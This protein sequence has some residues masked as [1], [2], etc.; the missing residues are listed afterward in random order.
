MAKNKK[1][2]WILWTILLYVALAILGFLIV[3]FIKN[4]VQTTKQSMPLNAAPSV[5]KS[6]QIT[7]PPGWLPYK[8]EEN[9]LSFSYPPETTIKHSSLGFGITSL[10]INSNDNKGTPEFQVL[11]APKYITQAAG[12]DF[13]KYYAMP[14]ETTISISSPLAKEK[15]PEQFTKMRNRTIQNYRALDYRSLPSDAKQ[16]DVAEIGVFIEAGDTII[17]ISTG[18]NNKEELEQL[19]GT[20]KHPI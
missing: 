18:E 8:N 16:G 1:H 5:S 19:V 12:Q 11:I 17:L 14:E 3:Y 9:H 13:N 7:P 4:T 20:F 15:V 10:E 2:P 6:P